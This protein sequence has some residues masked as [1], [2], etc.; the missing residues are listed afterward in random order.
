MDDYGRLWP[1]MANPRVTSQL[2]G[3]ERCSKLHLHLLGHKRAKSSV[4]ARL[5]TKLCACFASERRASAASKVF[6]KSA[7]IL[8]P[9]LETKPLK[10]RTFS[11]FSGH[12]RPL[13]VGPSAI[14][15]HNR[16]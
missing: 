4:F 12:N 11:G 10:V 5:F 2:G 14:S 16:P 1:I 8:C 3:Q 15:G 6:S 13:N 7:L 9:D